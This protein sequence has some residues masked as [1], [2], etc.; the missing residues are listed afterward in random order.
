M[1]GEAGVNGIKSVLSGEREGSG[2]GIYWRKEY[3]PKMRE[4]KCVKSAL[5]AAVINF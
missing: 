3:V 4:I 2:H 1:A 5:I